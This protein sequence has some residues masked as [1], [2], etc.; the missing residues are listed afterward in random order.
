MA[1]KRK[2][3]TTASDGTTKKKKITQPRGDIDL[4]KMEMAIRKDRPD[5]K[6][7]TM[8]QY[9]E[10]LSTLLNNKRSGGQ[11]ISARK[12]ISDADYTI[13]H[14]D[15]IYPNPNTRKGNYVALAVAARALGFNKQYERYTKIVS[16]LS[17]QLLNQA[18]TNTVPQKYIDSGMDGVADW[19]VLVQRARDMSNQ[20]SMDNALSGLMILTG[21]PRRPGELG[22]AYWYSDGNPF[23][24]TDPVVPRDTQS[25]LTWDDNNIAWNY[26]YPMQG[27]LVKMVIRSHKMNQN[28]KNGVYVTT[29]SKEVSS[30][31]LAYVSKQRIEDDTPLFPRPRTG[32]AYGERLSERIKTFLAELTKGLGW[33]Q[34]SAKDLRDARVTSSRQD[35][36]MNMAEKQVLADNMGHSASIQDIYY[37]RVPAKKEEPTPRTRAQ[38]KLVLLE[39]KEKLLKR[40][41]ELDELLKTL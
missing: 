7:T 30:I 27:G 5:L 14:M 40:L 12:L 37:N 24:D 29:L 11:P 3:D 34:L 28:A 16:G 32:E 31:I 20:G 18:M 38:K 1:G 8:K 9:R 39:E 17:E 36:T 26:L 19:N 4:P 23:G 13:G 22:D 15:T 25:L 10:K 2:L 33:P 35:T 41:M 21:A 6:E